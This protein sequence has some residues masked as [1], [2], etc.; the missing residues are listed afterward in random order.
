MYFFS[1]SGSV[2]LVLVNSVSIFHQRCFF[3]YIGSVSLILVIAV[4]VF[5]KTLF[6]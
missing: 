5:K 2:S 1:Y 6:Q 4:R 3:T